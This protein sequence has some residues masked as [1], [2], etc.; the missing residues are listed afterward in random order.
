MY[1][2]LYHRNKN[3][4]FFC[5]NITGFYNS[6]AFR[7]PPCTRAKVFNCYST[8]LPLTSHRPTQPAVALPTLPLLLLLEYKCNNSE[9]TKQLY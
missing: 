1:V 9:N 7:G 5:S 6:L 3:Y 2:V 4:I 8:F